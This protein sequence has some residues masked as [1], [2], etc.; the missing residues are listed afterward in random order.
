M[1]WGELV[2]GSI[3]P[4]GKQNDASKRKETGS[5]FYEGGGRFK[6][7]EETRN[8][9]EKR[10]TNK[11]LPRRPKRRKNKNLVENAGIDPAA[12]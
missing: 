5:R 1:G 7:N 11:H 8:G 2:C 12:S 10:E 3:S 4:A 6:R 9:K